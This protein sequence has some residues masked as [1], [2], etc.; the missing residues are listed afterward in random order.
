MNE[1]QYIRGRKSTRVRKQNNKKKF[2]QKII[3]TKINLCITKHK[4][5]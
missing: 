4:H 2:N 1:K 5:F 3:P